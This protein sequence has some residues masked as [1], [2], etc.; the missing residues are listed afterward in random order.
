VRCEVF[1]PALQYILISLSQ[2]L[3][4]LDY[5]TCTAHTVTMPGNSKKVFISSLHKK[6]TIEQGTMMAIKCSNEWTA[7]NIRTRAKAQT[8][9]LKNQFA[10]HCHTLPTKNKQ[11]PPAIFPGTDVLP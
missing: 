6:F 10:A 2:E 3:D 7:N 8:A 4:Y 11:I 5:Y 1:L 9:K